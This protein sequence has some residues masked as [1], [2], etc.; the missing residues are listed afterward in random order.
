MTCWLS[1]PLGGS[2]VINEEQVI[3][4][5]IWY[6]HS[7]D[8][9][10]MLYSLVEVCWCLGRMYCLPLQGE[11][12]STFLW[13]FGKLLPYCRCDIPEYSIFHVQKWI[14]GFHD[15]DC[16]DCLLG[17]PTCSSVDRYWRKLRQYVPLNYWYLLTRLYG[18]IFQWT[19]ILYFNPD[20][21]SYY[22]RFSF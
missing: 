17:C 19:V 5:E 21:Y 14:L 3:N 1:I 12:G 10:V 7:G 2:W 18:I 6:F 15:G 11:G 20:F 8:M 4:S 16:N 9:G 13:R 22:M